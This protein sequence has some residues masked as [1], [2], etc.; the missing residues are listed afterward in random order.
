MK[1]ITNTGH[2]MSIH[3]EEGTEIKSFEKSLFEDFLPGAK[4]DP[5]IG[6]GSHEWIEDINGNVTQRKY[7]MYA[8][9]TKHEC[10]VPLMVDYFTKELAKELTKESFAVI[11]WRVL[12]TLE[13]QKDA[14]GD[15]SWVLR[16]RCMTLPCGAKVVTREE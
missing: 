5:K 7:K 9:R 15:I 14:D 8:V 12:P 1:P 6:I 16:T 3:N 2:N 11:K 10:L 4:H 13:V